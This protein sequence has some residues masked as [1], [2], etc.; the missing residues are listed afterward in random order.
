MKIACFVLLWNA[1]SGF[2][3]TITSPSTPPKIV[4]L[5]FNGN[6]TTLESTL[7]M[8]LSNLGID[9]GELYDSVRI[10]QAKR[11][12][13]MTN[14]FYKVN[15]VPLFEE[16][17]VHLY[18]IIQ[19]LFYYIPTGT[20][21][22]YET[23]DEKESWL[24]LCV[25]LT[26]LNFRGRMET[27]SIGV[28]GWRD[29]SLSLAWSKPLLPST[30]Y[31][32]IAAGVRFYP[33]LNYPRT[34]LVESN[35]LFAGKDITVHSKAYIGIV[36]TYSRIDTLCAPNRFVK[37]IKEADASIGWTTDYRNN[38]F[39]PV[40]GWYFWNE[41]LTNGFYSTDDNKFG[42][43]SADFRFYIPGFFNRNHVACRLLGCFRTN[44]AGPYRRLYAGG[45]GSVRGFPDDYLGMTG[46]MNN[47]LV[48]STEYRFPIVTLPEID[49]FSL[50]SISDR[51]PELK[52]MYYQ[53]DGALIADAGD[54]WGHFTQPSQIR[55][56]GAGFGAGIKILIPTLRRSVCFDVVSPVTKDPSS[57]KTAI[58]SPECRL[59][60]DAYY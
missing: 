8:Y 21:E 20:L 19:E 23:T 46:E 28:S 38:N 47:S 10:A 51:F 48:V 14:L 26:K 41:A 57:G 32:G 16:D 60:L 1:L 40:A 7:R 35:R 9:T 12:L 3:D 43:Y 17:G 55:Q 22:Y 18:V 52:G 58:F 34:R 31:L 36:P 45:E 30:Y 5:S 53:I 37:E 56:N 15:F 4:S 42:Q 2:A 54:L 6:R 39:D 27:L 11:K 33:E 29:R 44:D 13:I 24:R 50:F 25:G 59:Y 49:V